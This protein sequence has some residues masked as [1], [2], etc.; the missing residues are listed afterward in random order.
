MFHGGGKKLKDL[1]EVI[2]KDQRN[3]YTLDVDVSIVELETKREKSLTKLFPHSLTRS[4]PHC[5][6]PKVSDKET[7]PLSYSG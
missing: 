1:R 2:L 6:Q 4:P 7:V 5:Q 3:G